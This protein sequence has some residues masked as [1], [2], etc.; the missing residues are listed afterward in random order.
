MLQA[1]DYIH[2]TNKHTCHM[3]ST[4]KHTGRMVEKGYILYLTK[5]INNV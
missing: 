5:N 1:G 2:I 4:N 3:H